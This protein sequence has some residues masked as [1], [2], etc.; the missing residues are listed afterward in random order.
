[1]MLRR[2]L[3]TMQRGLLPPAYRSVEY[4]EGNGTQYINI[5]ETQKEYD[6]EI[7]AMITAARTNNAQLIG[8]R[9]FNDNYATCVN[10]SSVYYSVNRRYNTTSDNDGTRV[11]PDTWQNKKLTFICNH[12]CAMI[13]DT[14]TDTVLSQ[15]NK[16]I[17]NWNPMKVRLFH[18]DSNGSAYESRYVS[19]RVFQV[20]YWLNGQLEY[21]LYPCI[22]KSDSK[23]GMYDTVSKTFYTNA[24]TGEFIVPA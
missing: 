7:T 24:G 2:S 18:S 12:S 17:Y 13:K 9:N 23:P 5:S 11:S 1:M 16:V 3:L 21:D 20:R 22:R 10:I 8:Y 14:D 4:I 6:F 15:N 19:A